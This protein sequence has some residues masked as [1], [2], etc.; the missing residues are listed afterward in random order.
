MPVLTEFPFGGG[1]NEH[2]SK[3]ML[4][5]GVLEY[6]ENLRPGLQ[7]ELVTRPGYTALGM[8]GLNAGTVTALDL[9]G[10]GDQFVCVGRAHGTSGPREFFV[11]N[12][13]GHW[14]WRGQVQSSG[15]L[16]VNPVSELT[17]IWQ[18][19]T[20][21]EATQADVA[22]ANGFLCCA[23]GG[24][25]GDAFVHVFRSDG[26]AVLA[27]A[28][29]NVDAIRCVGVG[30]VLV[31]ATHLFTGALE[32]RAFDTTTSEAFGAPV[33]AAAG[34]SATSIGGAW[35]MAPVDGSATQFLLAFKL[36]AGPRWQRWTTALAQVGA[37]VDVV[38]A[39][40]T[41]ISIQGQDAET[42]NLLYRNASTGNYVLRSY[43]ESTDALAVGPT[44][45]T[46]ASCNLQAAIARKS[47]TAIHVAIRGADTLRGLVR[48]SERSTATHTAA[49]T[50]T[51]REVDVTGKLFTFDGDAFGT[52][53]GAPGLSFFDVFA[54]ASLV[55]IQPIPFVHAHVDYG[56]SA[57][58]D[59]SDQ[60]FLSSCPSD[61]ATRRF[62]VSLRADASS[63][64]VADTTFGTPVVCSFLVGSEERRQFAEFGGALY[65]A[66]GTLNVFDGRENVDSGLP[67]PELTAASSATPGSVEDGSLS[68][69]TLTTAS[70]TPPSSSLNGKT[71]MASNGTGYQG[72]SFGAGDTTATAIAATIS[73]F[74][75][76]TA[77]VS[78]DRVVIAS[79][80]LGAASTLAVDGDPAA[81]AILGLFAGQSATGVTETSRYRY[82]AC[83]LWKDKLGYLHR[84]APS[85]IVDV[86]MTAGQTSVDLVIQGAH[87]SRR[88]DDTA[89]SGSV[90]QTELYRTESNGTVFRLAATL[91]NDGAYAIALTHND[92]LSDDDLRSRPVLYTQAVTKEENVPAPACGG[93]AAGN[94]RMLA[95]R[96][97]DPY[98]YQFSKLLRPEEPANFPAPGRV[99]Y[100]GRV[101]ESITAAVWDDSRWVI[102]TKRRPYQITGE[103]PNATGG[104]EFF[105]AR[106]IDDAP[107]G[108]LDWKGVLRTPKGILFQL[109]ADALYALQ[110][111]AISWV[112]E[113]IQQT[114]ASFPVIKACCYIREQQLAVY[115]CQN[116]GG[117]DGVLL[118]YDLEHDNW[119]VDDVGA[120]SAV[121]EYDGRIAFVQAGVVYLQDE[122]PGTGPMP[123]QM[124]RTGR[125]R[126]DTGL[127]YGALTGVGVLGEYRGGTFTLFLDISFNDGRTWVTI[128]QEVYSAATHAVGQ[129]IQL[130][131]APPIQRCPGFRLRF[132]VT[133]SDGSAGIVLN[134]LV[135]E[136]EKAY[137]LARLPAGE[138]R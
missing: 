11:Y 59:M 120:V 33:S 19:P 47:S 22:Y 9:T 129:T 21:F 7:G 107:G 115:A 102:F 132:R 138:T 125:F 105:A 14:D 109:R 5:D 126:H 18:G 70:V 112:G 29:T 43:N 134:S 8:D 57:C 96:L 127:G 81:L 48:Y 87:T 64:G 94:D 55:G 117:S 34:V 106:G 75:G 133:G 61:G 41:H 71:F 15:E 35:D 31:V 78:G 1:L 39:T 114:L 17:E 74:T 128:E 82:R 65:H 10:Y 99:A 136:T 77:T 104:G 95:V 27:L 113:R 122:A 90:V 56:I 54:S 4:P 50:V 72:V 130:L 135:T 2:V 80:T 85:P 45:I 123:T 116:T 23:F 26:R 25:G 36:A 66:G 88:N 62:F 63:I 137:A 97:V 68:A 101:H 84:S 83:H 6:C 98:A 92:G 93:I 76:I 38:D 16:A 24:A 58:L 53:A 52:Y 73:L 60:L 118:V 124:A 40:A 86:T 110:G 121:A 30:N 89:D 49:V 100:R 32:L 46:V 67:T 20:G 12:D 42:I 119:F 69:A 131:K 3:R 51:L 13:A 79:D 91:E 28:L 103:G 108:A 37:N 44:T 111:S